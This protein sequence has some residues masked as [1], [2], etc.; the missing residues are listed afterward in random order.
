MSD[1]MGREVATL[2]NTRMATGSHS[3]NFDAR[4]LSSGVYVYRLQTGGQIVSRK[5]V[6]LK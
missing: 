1:L 6:L 5:M 4:Q 3:V 2:V